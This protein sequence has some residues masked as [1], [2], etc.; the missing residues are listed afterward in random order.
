MNPT[1]QEVRKLLQE[2]CGTVEEEAGFYFVETKR[3]G[4]ANGYRGKSWSGY[5][6]VLS[7]WGEYIPSGDG[8]TGWIKL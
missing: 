8:K 7:L 3:V 4:L 6:S 2:N 1:I 5:L